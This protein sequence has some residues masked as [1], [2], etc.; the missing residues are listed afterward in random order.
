VLATTV[1]VLAA[2]PA[3]I[4]GFYMARAP[5][6]V[7][8]TDGVRYAFDWNYFGLELTQ[9]AEV[10]TG[11]FYGFNAS[12]VRGCKAQGSTS[13]YN[14]TVTGRRVLLD[15][16]SNNV[17]V[18]T[19]G[20]VGVYL[21]AGCLG[22]ASNS[23]G[24]IEGSPVSLVPGWNTVTVTSTGVIAVAV[25]M[26]YT[27]LGEL[28]GTVGSSRFALVGPDLVTELDAGTANITGVTDW[29]DNTTRLF[30]PG[31][32]FSVVGNGDITVTLPYGSSGNAT[33][34]NLT[35]DGEAS[36]DLEYGPNTL[37]LA[38][39]PGTLT[40]Y[41]QVGEAFQFSGIARTS[42]WGNLNK[43]T[44]Y[45]EGFIVLS[46]DPWNAA[47]LSTRYSATEYSYDPVLD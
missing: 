28:A 29:S 25:W 30:A 27:Y 1:P 43:L 10:V 44:G 23:T 32:S 37:T 6:R 21:T 40:V 16:G 35:V 12:S 18:T 3:D 5:T 2:T 22:T 45:L 7:Y 26:D 33:G 20:T 13:T 24:G 47:L 36:V 9:E 41:V 19:N 34:D 46:R 42:W 14:A 38:G 4:E 11:Y 15:W 39:S 8:D 31:D 17:T